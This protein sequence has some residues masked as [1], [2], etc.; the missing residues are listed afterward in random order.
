MRFYQPLHLL[1]GVQNR[2]VEQLTV[3]LVA[4]LNQGAPCDAHYKEARSL[5]AHALGIQSRISRCRALICFLWYYLVSWQQRSPSST[6][7][8][9][10]SKANSSLKIRKEIHTV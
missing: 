4:K 5:Q 2:V 6:T 1:L 7:V 10:V 3:G 8:Q 9:F